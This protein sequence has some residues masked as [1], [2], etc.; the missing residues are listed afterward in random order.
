MRLQS[1]PCHRHSL[2]PSYTT[3]TACFPPISPTQPASGAAYFTHDC[4]L[5]FLSY[6]LSPHLM[7][8]P[9]LGSE[10]RQT[11]ARSRAAKILRG[12]IHLDPCSAPTGSRYGAMQTV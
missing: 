12:S 8:R 2:L 3:D 9:L 7:L 1:H 10:T 5:G 11:S 4:L 6:A